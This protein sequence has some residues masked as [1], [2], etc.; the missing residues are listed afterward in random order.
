MVVLDARITTGSTGGLKRNRLVAPN[1]RE[2]VCAGEGPLI[3][4][5]QPWFP[6]PTELAIVVRGRSVFEHCRP[7]FLLP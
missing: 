4:Y 3:D 5:Q 7:P 6:F 1:W 2:F